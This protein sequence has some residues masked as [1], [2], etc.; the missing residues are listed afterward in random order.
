MSVEHLH[1]KRTGRPRGS[2]STSPWRRDALWAYRHLGRP[3]AQPPSE[4]AKLLLALGREQPDRL[5]ACLALL[6]DPGHPAE[7]PNREAGG[8]AEA[9]PTTGGR[10]PDPQSSG[11][12]LGGKPPQKVRKL[13][14]DARHLLARL[15]GD[16]G[17]WVSNLPRGAYVVGCETDPGRD[18]IVLLIHSEAFPPVAEGEAIPELTAEYARE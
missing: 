14:V 3:D 18:G 11:N 6:D 5:F 13:F 16:G 7:Q 10:S 9:D 15:T 2:K 8:S 12:D 1:G 4:L 17:A